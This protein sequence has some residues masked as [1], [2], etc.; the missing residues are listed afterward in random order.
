[1]TAPGD[2][3]LIFMLLA[4]FV[5]CCAYAAGRLH[6]RYQTA[7]DREEAYRDGYET[8]SSRVFSLA[9]RTLVPKRAA[10]GSAAVATGGPGAT[11]AD[12]PDTTAAGGPGTAGADSPATTAAG[13]AARPG[14]VP[15]QAGGPDRP[16]GPGPSRSAGPAVPGV[17]GPDVGAGTPTDE[18]AGRSDTSA[19]SSGSTAPVTSPGFPLPAPPPPHAVTEPAAVGGVTYR[20]FPDPRP[21]DGSGPRLGRRPGEPVPGDAP[22][23]PRPAT[24]PD[25][26]TEPVH[27][28]VEEPSTGRHT[29]P[30]ELVQAAT[31]RLPPDRIFRARV[32]NGTPL[33]EE[34]TT[35]LTVPKPRRSPSDPPSS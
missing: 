32:P 11:A 21:A 14:V 24:A 28:V 33:P 1:M 15:A 2:S 26:P 8:A 16:A 22:A 18:A 10:R 5:A 20:P 35:P 9:A 19:V 30:D 23:A 17:P 7:R 12:G 29:V 34:P 25:E 27:P 4:L 6:Q 31:Y 13:G 3:V